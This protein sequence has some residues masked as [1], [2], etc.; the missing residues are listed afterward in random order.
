MLNASMSPHAGA[1]YYQT[2]FLKSNPITNLTQIAPISE[3]R[4]PTVLNYIVKYTLPASSVSIAF[5]A[6]SVLFLLSYIV[7]R[8]ARGFRQCC[9]PRA[10]EDSCECVPCRNIPKATRYSILTGWL[11]ITLKILS[12]FI[13]CLVIVDAIVGLITNNNSGNV[14]GV[15]LVTDAFKVLNSLMLYLSAVLTTSHG[16][17]SQFGILAN[18]T[19]VFTQV[20]N[21]SGIPVDS[22]SDVARTIS[23]VTGKINGIVLNLNTSIVSTYY[24]NQV[25]WEDNAQKFWDI[26]VKASIVFYAVVLFF[27]LLYIVSLLFNYKFGLFLLIGLQGFMSAL[28]FGLCITLSIGLVAL[29]DSCSQTEQIIVQFL[30]P[31]SLRDLISF[32]LNKETANYYSPKDNPEISTH[33]INLTAVDTTI[34]QP[35][36]ATVATVM[37]KQIPGVDMQNLSKIAFSLTNAISSISKIM[38]DHNQQGSLMYLVSVPIAQ[39]NYQY[40]KSYLCC[41]VP[42]FIYRIYVSSMILG[43][44]CLVLLWIGS[45][46]LWRMDYLAESRSCCNCDCLTPMNPFASAKGSQYA[47]DGEAAAAYASSPPAEIKMDGRMIK[48]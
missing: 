47:T 33:F 17:V 32:Y 41:D 7:W 25:S 44:L 6:L 13:C 20:L 26:V 42:G 35:I 15:N 4:L 31:G 5:C 9:C 14:G 45:Y 48:G 27:T 11:T 30:S 23:D 1:D 40:T 46:F 18:A 21:S 2:L 29:R 37:S 10:C 3:W 12:L 28:F 22:V 8:L 24:N 43:W 36:N 16:L 19:V 39:N 34:L 38:G